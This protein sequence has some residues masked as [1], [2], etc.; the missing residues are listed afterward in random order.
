MLTCPNR[1]FVKG[2]AISGQKVEILK[3]L[4]FEFGER[5]VSGGTL[6]YALD[7]IWVDVSTV[8]ELCEL[9]AKLGTPLRLECGVLEIEGY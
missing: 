8:E 3:E 7:S 4:G 9:Q 5:S 1:Q 6:L 2:N